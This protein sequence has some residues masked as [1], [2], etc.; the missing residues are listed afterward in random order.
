MNESVERG[1]EGRSLELAFPLLSSFKM[2]QLANS[3]VPVLHSVSPLRSSGRLIRGERLDLRPA[4]EGTRSQLLKGQDAYGGAQQASSLLCLT[5]VAFTSSIGCS[6]SFGGETNSS[7]WL[8]YRSSVGLSYY[9]GWL[10]SLVKDCW[11]RTS[12][13][14]FSM[15]EPYC[16]SAGIASPELN[17]SCSAPSRSRCRCTA[18]L[19]CSMSD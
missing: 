14:P 19:S 15:E 11:G 6:S 17:V 8:S 16:R 1:R 4:R 7:A 12:C 5:I 10:G 13:L 18:L 2:M 9:D 3:N